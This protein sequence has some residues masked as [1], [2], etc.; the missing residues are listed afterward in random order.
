MKALKNLRQ[1]V[2]D[3]KSREHM[4]SEEESKAKSLVD[5]STTAKKRNKNKMREVIKS[6]LLFQKDTPDNKTLR[7]SFTGET[8][9]PE[10]RED[11]LDFHN[12]GQHEF[13]KFVMTCTLHLSSAKNTKR[14]KCKLHTFAK[15]KVTKQQLTNVERQKKIVSLCLRK[16]LLAQHRLNQLP[17]QDQYLEL[18]RAIADANEMPHKAEKRNA[19]EFL[20][21]RYE[22]L[23]PHFPTQD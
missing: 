6:S 4:N 21:E 20:H 23:L 8:A 11:L 9:T 16:R 17:T 3:Q 15:Q 22:I 13:L 7:N 12:I 14:K 5:N 19:R 18:P 10:Q 2:D 1:I